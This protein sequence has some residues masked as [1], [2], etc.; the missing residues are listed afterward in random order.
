MFKNELYV[1]EIC[2]SDFLKLNISLRRFIM[3]RTTD[4]H[5]YEIIKVDA[6]ELVNSYEDVHNI[7]LVTFKDGKEE[8]GDLQFVKYYTQG[9]QNYVIYPDCDVVYRKRNNMTFMFENGERF[10]L[11]MALIDKIYLIHM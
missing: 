3:G 7:V 6:N 9:I 10:I 11:P 2:L 1:T 4:K 5:K 8:N